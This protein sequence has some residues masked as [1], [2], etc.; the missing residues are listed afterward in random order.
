MGGTGH[1]A[2]DVYAGPAGRDRSQ[3]PSRCGWPRRSGPRF[4]ADGSAVV[5]ST[6]AGATSCNVVTG[7][8]SALGIRHSSKISQPD[9]APDGLHLAFISDAQ[10]RFRYE[11]WWGRLDGGEAHPLTALGTYLYQ[12]RC[13]RDGQWVYFLRD[14]H[15]VG[16][17]SL[18]RV[19]LADGT[20][21][22]V[23]PAAV[24]L[25]PTGD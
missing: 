20:V 12:P 24:L 2:W 25:A 6:G 18:W 14:E 22:E 15:A 19:G 5:A 13:S 23:I 16:E 1:Y 21:D 11:V 4:L 9:P 7:E 3:P 10:E 17:I 8:M